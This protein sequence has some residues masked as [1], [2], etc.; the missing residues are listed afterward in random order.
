M[1]LPNG[2]IYTGR[3]RV[4]VGGRFMEMIS[5]KPVSGFDHKRVLPGVSL[6]ATEITP[7]RPHNLVLNWLR[8]NDFAKIEM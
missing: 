3:W 6:Q 4:S 8:P 7:T 5:P 2:L 1:F